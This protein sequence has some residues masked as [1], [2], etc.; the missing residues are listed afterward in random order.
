MNPTPLPT[1]APPPAAELA[2]LHLRA[3]EA[4]GLLMALAHADRLVLLCHL[5]G[6]GRTVGELGAASGIRQPNLSQQL[7]VLR[8]EGLVATRRAGKHVHY[9]VGS[10]AV[11]AMLQ[12]LYGLYCAAPPA[13]AP[14]SPPSSTH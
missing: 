9:R 10:P 7:A 13:E 11:E 6:G 14:G 12:T 3:R 5:L 4:A 1:P 2:A 8:H